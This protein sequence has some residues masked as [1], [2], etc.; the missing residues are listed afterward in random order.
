MRFSIRDLLLVT[1]IVALV[2]GWGL[3]HWRLAS[4]CAMQAAAIDCYQ[5]ISQYLSDALCSAM[6]SEITTR[7]SLPDGSEIV[8]TSKPK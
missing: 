5:T 3:D 2:L 4:R 6:G 7:G 1:V 8:V